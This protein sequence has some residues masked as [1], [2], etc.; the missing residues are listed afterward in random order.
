MCLYAEI[1]QSNDNFKERAEYK[2]KQITQGKVGLF[3]F[4]IYV[5]CTILVNNMRTNSIPK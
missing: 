2:I 1:Q 5:V 4:C 3:V